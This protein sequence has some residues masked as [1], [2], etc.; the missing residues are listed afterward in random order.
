MY[1]LD[2]I[3]YPDLIVIQISD[4]IKLSLSFG[5]PSLILVNCFVL[6][7]KFLF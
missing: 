3:V 6:F 5:A 7:F 2:F 4:V 1:T